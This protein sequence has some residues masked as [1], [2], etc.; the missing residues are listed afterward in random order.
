MQQTHL[1]I[2]ARDRHAAGAAVLV[3]AGP[4]DD[5]VDTIAICKR[6]VERAQDDSHGALGAHVPIGR[7]VERLAP[8]VR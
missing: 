4:P 1:L 2:E 6:L 3:H 5:R 8:S 7:G